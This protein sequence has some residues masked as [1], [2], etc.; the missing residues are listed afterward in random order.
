MI[1]EEQDTFVD[2][3]EIEAQIKAKQIEMLALQQR[4]NE[5]KLS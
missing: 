5:L 3:G 4:I 2:F 1:A